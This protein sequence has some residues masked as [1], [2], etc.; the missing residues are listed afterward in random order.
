MDSCTV[1]SPALG[2]NILAVGATSS[3]PKAATITGA[4]GRLI[5]DS[6]GLYNYSSEGYPWVCWEAAYGL[7]SNSTK[8][9]DIDTIAFFS[10]YGPTLD[11]R[12]KPEIVA[13]GDKARTRE[14]IYL[15]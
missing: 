2:K 6:L 13:P 9:A 11:G 10:S 5:Y 1:Y 12:I 15:V 3:G 4:D 7:P 14:R 8:P